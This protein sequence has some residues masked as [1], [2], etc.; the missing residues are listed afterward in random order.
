MRS[1]PLGCVEAQLGIPT[2]ETGLNVSLKIK[3]REDQARFRRII[4]TIV[5]FGQMN[6]TL[7]GAPMETI[8]FTDA[9]NGFMILPATAMYD[10]TGGQTA[11]LFCRY[12]NVVYPIPDSEEYK[13]EKNRIGSLLGLLGDRYD[14]NA[15]AIIFQAKPNTI[16]VT[17]SRESLSLTENTISALQDL[18]QGFLSMSSQQLAS[19]CVRLESEQISQMWIAG[20]PAD[21]LT[22]DNK[23]PRLATHTSDY[24]SNGRGIGLDK[25]P[26]QITDIPTISRTYMSTSYPNFPNFRSKD[27]DMRLE[28]LIQSGF[29]NRGKIQ[30][31]RRE[32]RL[33]GNSPTDWFQRN[34]VAPLVTRMGKHPELRADR[35]YA[36]G[37]HLPEPK[38]NAT[39]R[40]QNRY[41][42]RY[43][44][45]QFAIASEFSPRNLEEYLPFLRNFIVLAYN[46]RDI[47]DR[48][49]RFPIMKNWLGQDR[50]YLAYIVP[51]V[52]D[53]AQAARD[54]FTSQGLTIVDLTKAYAWEPKEVIEPLTKITPVKPRKKGLPKLSAAIKAG[55]HGI[56]RDNLKA[57]DS[58]RVENPETVMRIISDYGGGQIVLEQTS[59]AFAINVAKQYGD[60][61]GVCA[62]TTQESKFISLGAKPLEEWLTDQVLLELQTNP[63]IPQGLS[64]T[65]RNVPP[66]VIEDMRSNDKQ[67]LCKSIGLHPELGRHFGVVNTMTLADRR[68]V[69]IADELISRKRFATITGNLKKIQDILQAV[70]VNPAY[71]TVLYKVRDAD[72]SIID[73]DGLLGLYSI[74][75]NTSGDIPKATPQ[76]AKK[77]SM[78]IDLLTYVLEG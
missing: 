1:A 56:S 6:A 62:N 64:L 12:G 30:S 2:D 37:A 17:P 28:A 22:S 41:S 59:N 16:A 44:E 55:E 8:S 72:L 25:L 11:R 46:R 15:K 33:K 26:D 51:R 67:K 53:K 14:R 71:R 73:I 70:P 9:V 57:E 5:K 31:F 63:R 54:F 38:K 77:R 21:L 50:D 27:V 68:I 75:Y 24:F 78:A 29:G 58:P 4:E 60:R 45:V 36:Y 47:G 3:N 39:T 66:K 61:I 23:I 32:Y 18:M 35:L 43:A 65:M 76:V 10:V 52:G 42:Y 49:D 40:E 48:L 19:E 74:Q 20:R 34:I 13:D 7:N 69:A